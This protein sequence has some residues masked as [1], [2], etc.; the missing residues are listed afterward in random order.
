[1]IFYV[2]VSV[3]WHFQQAGKGKL[4][5]VKARMNAPTQECF[6]LSIFFVVCSFKCCFYYY[7]CEVKNAS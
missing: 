3:C 6:P 5:F 7:L 1:M 2:I 4:N